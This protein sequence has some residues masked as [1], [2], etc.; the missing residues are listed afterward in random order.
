M[1]LI[2]YTN[3]LTPYRKYFYDLLYKICTEQGDQFRVLVMA[4]TEPGRPWKYKDL[5]GDYTILLDNKT[6]SRG[7]AHVHIN[8]NLMKML[9]EL[10]P[11]VVV[12]AGSYLCPGVWEIAKSKDRLGYKLIYWSE[13]HLNELRRANSAK[14]FI[15]ELLR[16]H[17]YKLFNGFW[18]AGKLSREFD[19][20]YA[21][22]DASYH[23][24]P[25]L[26]DEAKY[27]VSMSA[28]KKR[29][30]RQKLE[31]SE[32]KTSFFCPARLI[33][34]KGILEFLELMK[35]CPSKEEAVIVIAGSGE[36]KEAIER[37][38]VENGVD[39]RLL[40]QKT[41]DE[42]VELYA[43]SDVFLLPSLSDPNPLACI[44]A[45][46][47]KK[48]LLISE[49]CGNYP[50]VVRMGEN[51]YVFNYTNQEAAIEYIELMINA[52]ACWRN[53]AGLVSE[54]L[55]RDTYSSVE[56]AKRIIEEMKQICS[57]SL[58]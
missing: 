24:L 51:G 42:T 37:K 48:P 20:K 56:V 50:E 35:H 27:S 47:A 49:H 9:K 19:E 4:E 46:W 12:C 39:V 11:D 10:K 57:K 3:I 33:S 29:K 6:I 40:G 38:S 31:I 23:F 41:Q 14:L 34:V 21:S 22:P 17:I 5:K 45:L 55:A 18:Y 15:R 26:I 25:N 2:I 36:L 30:V 1:N 54:E 28:E 16:N 53:K 32:S 58:G 8:G 44:E 7:E 13:S 52:S 43:A